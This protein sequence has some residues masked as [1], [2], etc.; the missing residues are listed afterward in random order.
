MREGTRDAILKRR[1]PSTT[2]NNPE[3]NLIR[4]IQPT[5]VMWGAK[6]ALVQV[7]IAEQLDRALLNTDIIIYLDLGHIQM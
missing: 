2:R 5:L 3:P 4:L 6:D 7:S 1:A